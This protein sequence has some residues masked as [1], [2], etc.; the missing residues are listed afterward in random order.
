MAYYYKASAVPYTCTV[1]APTCTRP[2]PIRTEVRTGKY[3]QVPTVP[4]GKLVYIQIDGIYI[5]DIKPAPNGPA[6]HTSDRTPKAR[7]TT[8]PTGHRD[9]PPPN[10]DQPQPAHQRKFWTILASSDPDS[11]YPISALYAMTPLSWTI[12]SSRDPPKYHPSGHF[13]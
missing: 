9:T 6:L 10:I 7:H 5:T 4:P 1:R 2:L 8:Q 11:C 12:L 13:L 3:P